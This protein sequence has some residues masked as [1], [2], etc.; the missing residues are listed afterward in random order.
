MYRNQHLSRSALI[1]AIAFFAAASNAQPAPAPTQT[2]VE[3]TESTSREVVKATVSDAQRASR[4]GEQE[5]KKAYQAA[6]PEAT[7]AYDDTKR[8]VEK[9]VQWVD[10]KGR[11]AEL[12][13]KKLGAEM[14]K[15]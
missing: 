3:R 1:C 6:A 10:Q 4:Y 15:R 5:A 7:S 12:E 14:G 11:A 8:V 2:L 13:A 9:G